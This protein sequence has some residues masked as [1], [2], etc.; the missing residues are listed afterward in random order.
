MAEER[1]DKLMEKLKSDSDAQAAAF[2]KSMSDNNQKLAEILSR[3][4]PPPVVI[5]RGGGGKCIIC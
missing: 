5:H 4:P 2:N 3:P 1:H